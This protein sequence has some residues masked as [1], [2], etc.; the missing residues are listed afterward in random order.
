[1]PKKSNKIRADGRIA[2]QVYLGM[3]DGKRK[4]KTVYGATQKEASAKADELKLKLGKGIDIS[5]ENDSFSLWAEHWLNQKKF[6]VGT[7]Q[8][9]SYRLTIDKLN[10]YIGNA[11]ISQIRPYDIQRIIND[12]AVENPHTKKPS[13]KR[14]LNLI[15]NTAKQIFKFL[16]INRIIEYNPTEGVTVPKKAPVNHR[17]ALTVQER[18]WIDETEHRMQIC[19]M[20]M[21]YAGLRRGEVIPLKWSDVDL[22]KGAINVNKAVEF[23]SSKPVVKDTKTQAGNRIVYIPNVLIQYLKNE[24]KQNALVC[25]SVS[26]NMHT[27]DSFRSGWNSYLTELDVKY[28]NNGR[29][30][31]FDPRYSGIQ[32]EKIT[33]HML[34][35]TFCTMMYENGVDVLTAKKQMGH[36][37]IK[38]TLEIYTHLSEE[39]AAE[40]MK[41]MNK[42]KSYAS[43]N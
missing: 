7:S 20:I 41:K 42:C 13:S 6:D 43:Q 11:S 10:L 34:R 36:T 30:S 33:P 8:Y 27:K 9:D 17:R 18:K 5:S 32:I 16:V 35:H 19:A 1:M 4:Y 24:E 39:H 28:G 3:V 2:V 37:D 14:L 15:L 29:N 21:M 25:P 22:D 31:K 12:Y 40:E 23:I 26:G 38:T